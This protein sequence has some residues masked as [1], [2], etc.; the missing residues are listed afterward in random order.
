MDIIVGICDRML[1]LS[2]GEVI[3]HRHPARRDRRS[4][5]DQ[6]LP[7][8]RPCS[9]VTPAPGGAARQPGTSTPRP[10]WSACWPPTP[11]AFPDRVAMREKDR[12]IWQE[13][14]WAQVHET[15][16]RCAAGLQALGLATRP[17]GADPRRQPAAP[18][19]GDAGRRRARGVRRC[20]SIRTRRPRRSSTSCRTSQVPLRR[21]PRTRSRWTRCWNCASAARRCEHIV[22]DDPRGMARYARPRPG[23]VAIAGGNAAAARLAAEAGLR[24]ALIALAQ[25]DGPRGVHPL[26]GHH[27]QAEGRGPVAPQHPGRRAQCLPGQGAF[28]FGEE[29]LAYLPMAWVGDFAIT[30]GAGIALQLRRSTS[31]SGRR[32]S[33]TTCARS[34][35]RSTWRRRAAG[36]TCSPPSRCGWRTRRRLK[37]AALRLLHRVGGRGRTA[38]AGG[39][40]A[41]TP[42]SACCDRSANC[43]S[44]V[45]SRTSWA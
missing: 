31:P 13:T 4:A 27:R 24:E 30:M 8:E 9:A 29:V 40:A 23:V 20:R 12:G 6:G 39:P 22:Y 14:T 44:W 38:Q 11:R 10:P 41:D 3:E 2:Y 26:F 34:R 35:R 16:L 1:V 42:C 18:V 43:W 17:G 19:H 45:R 21:S 32:R 33:C 15:V 5:R 25:P 36:T 7:R 37:K 28:S